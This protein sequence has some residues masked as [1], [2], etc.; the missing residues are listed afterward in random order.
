MLFK[1]TVTVYFEKHT[2][3]TYTVGEN[4]EFLDVRVGVT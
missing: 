3:H 2:K 1:E 4:A